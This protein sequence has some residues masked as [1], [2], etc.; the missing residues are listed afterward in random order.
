MCVKKWIFDIKCE[1]LAREEIL[2]LVREYCRRYHGSP[3]NHGSQGKRSYVP[4]DRISYAG[5]VYDETEMVNLAD[6]ALE[7]WLTAGRYT[8]RFE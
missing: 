5:R 2:E 6:S 8:T 3:S 4:G 7:F 1:C